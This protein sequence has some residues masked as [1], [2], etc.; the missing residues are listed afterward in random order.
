M[1]G[2]RAVVSIYLD[3]RTSTGETD[4]I[5]EG[6]DSRVGL[7]LLEMKEVEYLESGGNLRRLTVLQVLGG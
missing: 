5:A 4:L 7:V 6:S 1:G 3:I 2:V